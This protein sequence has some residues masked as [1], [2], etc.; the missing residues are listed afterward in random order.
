MLAKAL[1]GS[2]L[3]YCTSLFRGLKGSEPNELKSFQDRI[4]G[5]NSKCSHI[6]TIKKNVTMVYDKL[7][8]NDLPIF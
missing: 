7:T 1:I 8:C 4:V 2:H 5:N 3:D 6:T